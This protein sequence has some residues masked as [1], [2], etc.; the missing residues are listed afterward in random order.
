[1]PS[2]LFRSVLPH[3]PLPVSDQGQGPVKKDHDGGGN[4]N[5]SEIEIEQESGIF[6]YVHIQGAFLPKILNVCA[7]NAKD[8]RGKDDE[9]RNKAEEQEQ[10]QTSLPLPNPDQVQQS[11]LEA[12]TVNETYVH[13]CKL[14]MDSNCDD[15]SILTTLPTYCRAV[16]SIEL[17]IMD[18]N[19]DRN[20]K[21]DG[22]GN[23]QVSITKA[24][25]TYP[26]PGIART[27]V[28]FLRQHKI[29][30]SI[31]FPI[32]VS[33]SINENDAKKLSS[34]HQTN[35][36]Y[37]YQYSTKH[38]Q[39]TQVT[40][41]P[42]PPPSIA[43]PRVGMPKFRRLLFNPDSSQDRGQDLER[44][45]YE[46]NQTR[47]VF[48]TNIFDYAS[49]VVGDSDH[50][51][52][53]DV[54]MDIV[55]RMKLEPYLF[56]DAIRKAIQP[57]LSGLG[58]DSVEAEGESQEHCQLPPEIFVPSKKQQAP[59]KYCHIGTRSPLHAQTII[60]ELQGKQI[61]L[62]ID[63]V[64]SSLSGNTRVDEKRTVKITTGKLF[65]DFADVTQRSAAKSNRQRLL[66]PSSQ[67]ADSMHT[68]VDL[69]GEPSRP[70][71]TSTT[72]STTVPGLVCLHDFV[73]PE[74]EQMLLACLTGPHAPWAPSQSN[75]SKTGIVKR[76]VQHYGYV[77][78]YETAD[79]LRDRGTKDTGIAGGAD[80]KENSNAMCPP[81]PVLP[82]GYDA[83]SEDKLNKFAKDAIR[84]GNGWD[85]LAIVLER[86]RRYEFNFGSEVVDS[87]SSSDA[88]VAELAEKSDSREADDTHE[89]LIAKEETGCKEVTEHPKDV[90]ILTRYPNINQMTVNEYKRGQGIG[91]H[92]DTKS[93][94]DDGLMSLSLGSD[95]VM[96]FRNKGN[97]ESGSSNSTKK[98]VH[99][100][101][102]S[103]LLMS[104]AARY[105]WSHQIVT[106]MTDC[107][108]G[109]LIPRK[110]RVSLTLRTAIS[111]PSEIDG[112]VKPMD[113]VE[114]RNYPPKWGR[115]DKTSGDRQGSKHDAI[116]DDMDISTPETER[117]HVHAVYD[118]IA[119]QWHHTRGKRG[120]L[121]PGATQFLKQLPKGSIVADVGCGDGKY[122]PA[123]WEAGSYVIGTDISEPLLQTSIGACSQQTKTT[124]TNG[125][126]SSGPQNRQVSHSNIGLNARPALAVADCMHIPL[127]S[128][129]CDAAICI[130]VMHHLS[131]APR[132][133]RCLEELSRVVKTGGRIN[134]QA[135]ALEQDQN[136][137]R[138]FA[139]TDVFVPFNAQPR[140]LDRIEHERRKGG[141][142]SVSSNGTP[143]S[144]S[145]ENQNSTGD[146]NTNDKE[147]KGV[148]EMYSDAYDG[149]EYDERKG[150]VV[151][152]RYCHMYKE[153]ELEDIVSKIDS[154][155]M[156]ESGF[157]SGNHFVILKV[158]N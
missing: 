17:V 117:N 129:S 70:D 34:A 73:S 8:D 65:L 88:E 100:P 69:P 128:K 97:D 124:N 155:E 66:H 56:Q 118:A 61:T 52:G 127:K 59:F 6:G 152:Q 92:I 75:F 19:K 80:E 37:R 103:L 55:K 158:V 62:E 54:D 119:T 106:R 60:R 81:M 1:M 138:K 141:S 157:E 123:I 74:E 26:S 63:G 113:K 112:S 116:D 53:M 108:D 30:P 11:L 151:F 115:Y 132:R 89:Q 156:V 110:T 140:Y 145:A 153:G 50:Y 71:C 146:K 107:V 78:D 7:T 120:V 40:Q 68:D 21:D 142:G 3:E 41:I 47:F 87:K 137:R 2:S 4:E 102:R 96:E 67:S 94:F 25:I 85:V 105:S 83:W 27:V 22:G 36:P 31:L 77:F 149:A 14:A 84:D 13:N 29:S 150:L 143:R 18:G 35:C 133:R 154:L 101:P 72:A 126:S 122:F 20:Q 82:D 76:R 64:P 51:H 98:L 147:C 23:N 111:L 24:R 44:I 134:V 125:T 131:T 130:A 57:L 46:R 144:K 58:T 15:S 16:L 45:Q 5:K 91:S 139:G 42:L 148:A 38:I 109:K 49:S 10:A 39:A 99:L 9:Q 12:L 33:L 32:P 104:G 90:Q 114:S 136:S 121:W 135:W 93:A 95:S 48:M 28:A 43:W 79:V 86:V